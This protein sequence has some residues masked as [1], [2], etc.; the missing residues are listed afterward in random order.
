M[1]TSVCWFCEK[2]SPDP[3]V[4]LNKS[5]YGI[6]ERRSA[7][8]VRQVKYS[9]LPVAIPRCARCA[10]LHGRAKTAFWAPLITGGFVGLF[11]AVPG[12]IICGGI[13]Y[14]AGKAMERRIF[15]RNHIKPM[16]KASLANHPLLRDKIASG[17]TLAKPMA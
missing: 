11:G 8:I 4:T 16:S 1:D 15:K 7:V 5:L 13:G 10:K 9:V 6:L 14:L 17:W 3:R 12:L 2:A